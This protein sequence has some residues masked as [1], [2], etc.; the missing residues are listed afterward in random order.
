[1]SESKWNPSRALDIQ[2]HGVK[3]LVWWN[4]PTDPTELDCRS[5]YFLV[6]SKYR[7]CLE[8]ATHL[9]PPNAIS[10][11]IFLS[12]VN[13][14]MVCGWL[15]LT[16]SIQRP[17]S[18][19]SLIQPLGGKA[20]TDGTHLTCLADMRS[21]SELLPTFQRHIVNNWF[22]IPTLSNFIFQPQTRI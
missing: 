19:S 6:K 1:M 2:L 4:F 3:L 15:S 22:K 5:F 14:T 20:N 12:R 10:S 13:N 21:S 8:R 7:F 18:C 17:A 9:P 11:V 16:H